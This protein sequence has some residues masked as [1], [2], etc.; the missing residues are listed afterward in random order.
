MS[1]ADGKCYLILY[2]IGPYVF[3][4]PYAYKTEKG[5]ID[6]VEDLR[7]K[8]GKTYFSNIR[9]LIAQGKNYGE[10]YL[11]NDVFVPVTPDTELLY[12]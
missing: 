6:A 5:V 8:E 10:Y 2:N 9:V 11:V 3:H 1:K 4:Q 7:R 12:G